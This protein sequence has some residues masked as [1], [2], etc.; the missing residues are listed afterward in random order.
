MQSGLSAGLVLFVVAEL[1]LCACSTASGSSGSARAAGRVVQVVAA[2]NFW[3]SI[4]TQVG[5]AH[6]QVSSII[7]NPNTDPHVYEPTAADARTVAGAQLVIENGIG[8]DPWVTKFL[9]ADSANPTVLSVGGLLGVPDGANPHRWYNPTDVQAVIGQLVRDLQ[10][11][12]P[13]DRA[14]FAAQATRF[15]TVSLAKY[16]AAIAAINAGYHGVKVGASESI[17]AM[18]APALGINLITPSSFLKA[19][20]EGTDVSAADKQ[21]IDNQINAHE[22]KVYVYNSQNVTPDVQAQLAEVK[23]QRIPYATI[24]ETLVPPSATY[25][26]WQTT[27]LLGIQAALAKA[28]G[29]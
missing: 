3:G 17:F 28:V 18:L 21:T 2:E 6:A 29:H 16:H 1:G 25:Q 22:I 20:S 4:A 8:Y 19:I 7:S 26:D 5:G 9:A 27:Q 24:T 11:L 15:N 14:Y 12:D 23:A 13:A 10:K